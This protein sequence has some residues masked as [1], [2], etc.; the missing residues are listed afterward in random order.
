MSVGRDI[1]G[2]WWCGDSPGCQATLQQRLPVDQLQTDRI[3]STIQMI[4]RPIN[5]TPLLGASLQLRPA[6]EV[7]NTLQRVPC[8]FQPVSRSCL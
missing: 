6:E 8:N 5:R 2:R 3:I 4:K 7:V 1:R